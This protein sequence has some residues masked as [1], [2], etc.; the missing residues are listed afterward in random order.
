M[1]ECTHCGYTFVP[2][3]AG[4]LRIR[5]VS[6]EMFGKGCFIHRQAVQANLPDF[7]NRTCNPLNRS[8]GL[9]CVD[10]RPRKIE[11]K[12]EK[13]IH[14]QKTMLL[15]RVNRRQIEWL[16]LACHNWTPRPAACRSTS[17]SSLIE[18]T[19]DLLARRHKILHDGHWFP[20]DFRVPRRIAVQH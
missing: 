12:I 10:R 8:G 15:Q 19:S 13:R 9:I 14:E 2:V 4:I 17:S 18:H 11:E 16:N 3:P 1:T 20:D 6:A 5:V 7:A